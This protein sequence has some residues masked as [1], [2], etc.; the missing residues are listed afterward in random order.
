MGGAGKTHTVSLERGLCSAEHCSTSNFHW[1]GLQKA[2]RRRPSLQAQRSISHPPS[3][4][5]PAPEALELD[6]KETPFSVNAECRG[7]RHRRTGPVAPELI[8]KPS[9]APNSQAHRL[10]CFFGTKCLMEG[11]Q[12]KDTSAHS[13]QPLSGQGAMSRSD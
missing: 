5:P 10:P 4:R 2:C 8:P 11:K 13:R 12:G 6:N 3:A 1:N 7:R 9:V